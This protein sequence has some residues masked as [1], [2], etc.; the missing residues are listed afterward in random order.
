RSAGGSGN[1]VLGLRHRA[2]EAGSVDLDDELGVFDVKGETAAAA[3][4]AEAACVQARRNI[5][6][7]EPLVGRITTR[8]KAHDRTIPVRAACLHLLFDCRPLRTHESYPLLK[9]MKHA[10]QLVCCG[11]LLIVGCG[12]TACTSKPS[13]APPPTIAPAEA[14]V[15]PPAATPPAGVVRPMAGH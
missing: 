4:L 9:H 11:V 7:R 13:D 6:D 15:S 5:F 2:R 10:G 3:E 14:A 12:V 1:Y 8:R